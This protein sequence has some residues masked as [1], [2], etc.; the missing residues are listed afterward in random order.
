[1]MP[2]SNTLCSLQVL[3]RTVMVMD[4]LGVGGES[5]ETVGE[6]VTIAGLMFGGRVGF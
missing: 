6:G 1:M 3:G 2:I 5:S 4:D